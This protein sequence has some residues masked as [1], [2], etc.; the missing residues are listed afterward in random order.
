MQ[1]LLDDHMEKSFLSNHWTDDD[2]VLHRSQLDELCDSVSPLALNGVLSESQFYSSGRSYIVRPIIDGS[3]SE[4][5]RGARKSIGGG[6]KTRTSSSAEDSLGSDTQSPPAKRSM[7][8]ILNPVE[9]PTSV[10]VLFSHADF[11]LDLQF[12]CG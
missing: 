1:R 9:K 12:I 3:S 11:Q 8:N 4:A 6:K 7:R 5:V 10:E 2:S